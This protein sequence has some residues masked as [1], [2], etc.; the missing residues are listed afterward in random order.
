MKRFTF[1][2]AILVLLIGARTTYGSPMTIVETP[3]ETSGPFWHNVFHSASGVTSGS[4]YYWIDLDH[5]TY[6]PDTGDLDL[7]V[8]LYRDQ[9][10]TRYRGQAHGT[11][12][13]WSERTSTT[14]TG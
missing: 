3:Q 2:A 13:S 11:S 4:I 8:N 10:M 14:T 9:G 5:G 1:L 12:S 7:W 6:D